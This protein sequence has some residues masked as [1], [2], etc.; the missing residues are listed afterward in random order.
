MKDIF[1]YTVYFV[2][3]DEFIA[4]HQFYVIGTQESSTRSNVC[5]IVM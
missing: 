2:V 1:D 3:T 5:N 4:F